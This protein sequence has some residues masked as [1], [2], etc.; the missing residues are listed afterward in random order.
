MNETI[1]KIVKR[2][3]KC[4]SE[5]HDFL[6]KKNV[7]IPSKG[8]VELLDKMFERVNGSDGK[9]VRPFFDRHFECDNK[10]LARSILTVNI[11]F[12]V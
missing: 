4:F 10:Q 7:I 3:I 12:S 2:F 8:A 5:M 1:V 11:L 6:V 9:C